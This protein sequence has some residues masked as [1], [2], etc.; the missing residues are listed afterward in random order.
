M[1]IKNIKIY[2]LKMVL[3]LIFTFIDRRTL[4]LS[5]L[6]FGVAMQWYQTTAHR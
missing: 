4:L 5:V 1:Q 3:E 6:L 2:F